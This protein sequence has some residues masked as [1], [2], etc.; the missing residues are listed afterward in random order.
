MTQTNTDKKTMMSFDERV[1]VARNELILKIK[2]T[3]LQHPVVI[4]DQCLQ[5]NAIHGKKVKYWVMTEY[6]KVKGL[7][8]QRGWDSFVTYCERPY[9]YE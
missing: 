5:V 4:S 9:M 6:W 2:Q 7:K 3:L 8:D 1:E